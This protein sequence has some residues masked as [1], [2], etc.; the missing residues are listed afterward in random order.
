MKPSEN[1]IGFEHIG[2][3][4]ADY[5]KTIEFY[6]TFG[7]ELAYETVYEGNRVGFLRL[8]GVDIETWEE[9]NPALRAGAVDH[10][11][12]TVKDVDAIYELAVSK[13]Y[14]IKDPEGIRVLP[15]WSNGYRFVNVIGP[16]GE[17]V[18]FG[19]KL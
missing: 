3:P 10:F 18:E 9:A 5:D 14:P 4:S 12:L 19:H 11:A 13:G 8:N 2:L 16:N 6:T 15:F 1:I 7:F 17:T